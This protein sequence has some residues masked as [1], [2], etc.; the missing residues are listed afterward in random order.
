MTCHVLPL[1]ELKGHGH[2][3]YQQ[4]VGARHT[5]TI[6]TLTS[7]NIKKL[8]FIQGNVIMLTTITSSKINVTVVN[9]AFL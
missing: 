2:I 8:Q 4:H 9:N 7:I 6:L 3:M 5:L 1:S